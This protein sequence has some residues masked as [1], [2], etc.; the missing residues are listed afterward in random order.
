MEHK[1]SRTAVSRK[2]FGATAACYMVFFYLTARKKPDMRFRVSSTRIISRMT[3]RLTNIPLP[4]YFRS[5]LYTAFGKL[6]GV[7]FDDILV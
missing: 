7:N 6:Y 3:G 4:P 5:G 1:V 2:I